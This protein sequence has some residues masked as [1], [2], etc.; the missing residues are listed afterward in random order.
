MS[1]KLQSL[2]KTLKAHQDQLR[3]LHNATRKLTENGRDPQLIAEVFLEL[4]RLR[5]AVAPLAMAELDAALAATEQELQGESISNEAANQTHRLIEALDAL[6]RGEGE[7]ALLDSLATYETGGPEATAGAEDLVDTYDDLD[8]DEVDEY[9]KGAREHIQ[10]IEV[11]LVELEQ[12]SDNDT[13]AEVYRSVQSIRGGAQHLGLEGT[14]TLCLLVET[15]LDKIQSGTMSLTAG[16]VEV[17]VRCVDTLATLISGLERRQQP[18]IDSVG[19]LTEL[20]ACIR[21]D[22]AASQEDEPEIIEMVEVGKH[23]DEFELVDLTGDSSAADEAAD[24]EVQDDSD[25]RLFAHDIE[26]SLTVLRELLADLQT[27]VGAPEQVRE[28]LRNLH[29]VTGIAELAEL[30]QVERLAGG[31]EQLLARTYRHR[32]TVPDDIQ[33]VASRS[34]DLLTQTHEQ[35]LSGDEITVEVDATVVQLQQLADREQGLLG[36]GEDHCPLAISI[37]KSNHSFAPMFS[38][39]LE[40]A[41]LGEESRSCAT[42]TRLVESASLHGYEELAASTTELRRSFS[43]LND[44]QRQKQIEE[45]AR[46]LPEDVDMIAPPP[47]AEAPEL[48]FEELLREVPGIGPKKVEAFLAAGITDR[49][50]LR[51]A[52]IESLIAFPGVNVDQAK[53][54][55][56]LCAEPEAPAPAALVP[57]MPLPPPS[58]ADGLAAAGEPLTSPVQLIDLMP[59]A[60]ELVVNRSSLTVVAT[61]IREVVNRMIDSGAADRNDAAMLRS[62]VNRLDEELGKLAQVSGQVQAAA[63]QMRMVPVSILLDR[64][65]RLVQALAERCQRQVQVRLTGTETELDRS[66]IRQLVEPLEQ[67][68]DNAV[69][70]GIEPPEER[71][72]ADKPA[73]GQ[74]TVAA[75]NEGSMVVIEVEDD[76][77]GIDLE[78]VRQRLVA[79]GAATDPDQQE[80]LAALLRPGLGAQE[81]GLDMVRSSVESLGGQVQVVTLTGA[82]SRLTIRIPLATAIMQ[83]LLVRT[84]IDTYAIPGTA[85]IETVKLSMSQI[86]TIEDRQVLTFRERQ[87]PLIWLRDLFS[88]PYYDETGQTREPGVDEASMQVVVVHG[89]GTEIGLVA[90]SVIDSQDIVLK[91]LD[92]DL[93]RSRGLAGAAILGDG[94]VT[95]VLDVTELQRMSLERLT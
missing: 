84:G 29:T 73:A 70:H 37:A 3:D 5:Q 50:S 82:S 23:V 19:M 48:P 45:L 69:R 18:V 60:A 22:A 13:V 1:D 46:S 39:L 51:E 27:L 61:T 87:A 28:L 12:S 24:T 35:L 93:I 6:A 17:M 92:D 21:G 91:S 78:P 43:Q 4:F 41:E 20:A 9:C 95:F 56:A 64:A 55:L 88:Y 47:P 80:L 74:L 65:P 86:A 40:A 33:V 76:G 49:P 72:A 75:C 32:E 71:T 94:T 54:L 8:P 34:L 90:D 81:S 42:L 62:A 10:L 14:S 7:Q 53:M 89:D 57:E 77:R 63:I 67:L 31:L 58:L 85:V 26:Q 15:L 2:M 25:A 38:A 30:G 79:E 59:T 36:W 11:S 44:S 83:A 66:V 16:V 68:L 52:G